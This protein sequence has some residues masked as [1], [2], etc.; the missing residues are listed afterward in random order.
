MREDLAKTIITNP[1]LSDSQPENAAQARF[2]NMR[3]RMHGPEKKAPSLG[4]YLFQEV[5]GK[6]SSGVVYRAKHCESDGIVAIKVFHKETVP[7]E[8]SRKRFQREMETLSSLSHPNVVHILCYGTDSTGSPY[9]VTELVDGESVR[10]SLDRKNVFQPKTAATIIKEVCRGLSYIHAEGYVHRDITPANILVGPNNIAKIVDFGLAKGVEYTGDTVTQMGTVVGTPAYMSPEQCLGQPVDARSDIYSLGCMMFEMLTGMKAFD[11]T[12]PVEIIAKQISEDRKCVRDILERSTLPF[13]LQAIVMKCLERKPSERFQSISQLEHDLNSF[14]LNAPLTYAAASPNRL[15]TNSL[16]LVLG[17]FFVFVGIGYL[18][19][20]SGNFNTD[21]GKSL[22]YFAGRSFVT[23]FPAHVEIRNRLTGRPIFSDNTTDLRAALQNA[24]LKH[25]SLAEADLRHADLSNANLDGL[26][27]SNADLTGASLVQSKL[28]NVDMHGANLSH[29]QMIQSEFDRV[30]LQNAK[31]NFAF[32]SQIVAPGT[33]MQDSDLSSAR[34]SQAN[35]QR[36]N[37]RGASFIDADLNQAHFEFADLT[38][39]KFQGARLSS[40][41]FRGARLN[42]ANFLNATGNGV[43][44][45]GADLSN[46]GLD[47][48]RFDRNGRMSARR[49]R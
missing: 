38:N 19:L 43:N 16:M 7:D 46:A 18:W 1:D 31:L 44:V 35:L 49:Y 24:S 2:M 6:G 41:Q 15:K 22:A 28:S 33:N 32:L 34:L 13:N 30:N 47:M 23:G 25:V 26:D 3:L 45:D 5:I 4:D 39:A 29:A 21:K 12:N 9:M 27:L 40:A 42:F 14:V 37:C 17:A 8:T 11:S 36:S 20:Q 10:D 48:F